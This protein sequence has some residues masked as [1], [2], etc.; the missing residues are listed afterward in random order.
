MP[1][2]VETQMSVANKANW[3][4]ATFE[5]FMDFSVSRVVEALRGGPGAAAIL[6]VAAGKS[7]FFAFLWTAG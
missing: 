3:S 6:R 4:A 7:Y 2:G 5:A 1:S